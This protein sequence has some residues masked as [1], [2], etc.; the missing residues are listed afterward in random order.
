MTAQLVTD[1]PGRC[2][3]LLAEL[4]AHT[5]DVVLANRPAHRDVSAPFQNHLLDEQPV[6][7][8]SRP[9]EEQ[10]APFEFPQSL[11]E[12]PVILPSLDSEMRRYFDRAL[13][14]A[15]IRPVVLAEVDDMAMLRLLARESG[16]LALVPPIVVQDE[17]RAGIR[18]ERCRIPDF[19][20]RLYAITQKRRYAN[21]LLGELLARQQRR[22]PSG[23]T[24][25]LV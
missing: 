1:A 6:S 18:V 8:V 25:R 23:G 24:Q 4:E 10:A 17:L 7:L 19:S 2:A 9:H 5:L 21:S 16:A 20:E 11:R 3:K 13:G 22:E 15:G 14:L 12:E